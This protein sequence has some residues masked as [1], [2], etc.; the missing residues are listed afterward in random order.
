MKQEGNIRYNE[1]K[2]L[3]II[4]GKYQMKEKGDII[5]NRKEILYK[6][7]NMINCMD[8]SQMKNS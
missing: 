4:K 3:D 1:R 8:N 6:A 2:I 7:G 5:L